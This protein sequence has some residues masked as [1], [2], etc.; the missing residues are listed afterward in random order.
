MCLFLAFLLISAWPFGAQAKMFADCT[1]GKVNT[2]DGQ[3]MSATFIG[4]LAADKYTS[5]SCVVKTDGLSHQNHFFQVRAKR[6][7]ESEGFL[8]LSAYGAEE[9]QLL[10]HLDVSKSED[11]WSSLTLC[12]PRYNKEVQDKYLSVSGTPNLAFTVQIDSSPQEIKLNEPKTVELPSLP[13][14]TTRVFQFIPTEDISDTQLDVTVTSESADVPAYL[15]VSRDCKDVK[16]NIYVVDYK[17]ESLRLS[18]S[19]KGRITLSKVSIPPLTD[20]TSSWFIGIAIKNASGSTA[21]KATKKVTLEL[22]KSFDY[23]YAK[24]ITILVVVSILLG[25]GISLFANFCFKNN[26]TSKDTEIELHPLL[27]QL[28]QGQ[29]S[30]SSVTDTEPLVTLGSNRLKGAQQPL[31][32]NA[33]GGQS[34]STH[35][36]PQVTSTRKKIREDIDLVSKDTEIELHPLLNQLE[37]GQQSSSSAP[38]AQQPLSGNA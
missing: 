2:T 36:P 27:N 19:K 9:S 17:G 6:N 20:T 7:K 30:S 35:G 33:A 16:D 29:Q 38:E 37:Q 4:K 10:G 22:R 14:E 18:F 3:N 28:E 8:H 32:S 21:T 5:H 1:F 34:R 25:F 15:K 31:S 24:P 11:D 13:P 23:S 12:P 26:S